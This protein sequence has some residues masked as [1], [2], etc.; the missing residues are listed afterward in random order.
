MKKRISLGAWLRRYWI[1]ILIFCIIVHFFSQFLFLKRMT[2]KV[3]KNLQSSITIAESYFE[4]SLQMVD[5]FI[6]DA[7][8]NSTAMP[9]SN[10]FYLLGHGNS[11]EMTMAKSAITAMLKN[12]DAW[13]D[14]VDGALF[15]T[16]VNSETVLLEAGSVDT[17]TVRKDL[18][19]FIT[20]NTSQDFGISLE[21]YMLF[22]SSGK[23]HMLRVM[24]LE[25]CYFVVHVS[26]NIVMQTLQTAEYDERSIVFAADEAGNIIFSSSPVD[27]LLK[28]ECEGTYIQMAGREYLQTGYVSPRTDYYFGM[29]TD[30]QS[31]TEEMWQF[32][33]AFFGLFLVL[34][35]FIPI[36]IYV[37]HKKLEQPLSRIAAAMKRIEEG[38]LEITVDETSSIS[39][40]GQLINSFNHMM[41]RIRELKIENY[42]VLLD[43]QKVTM[44]YLSLQIKPHFY[45]NALNMIYSLAETKDFE[46]IQHISVAISNYSR[47]RFHDAT[48]LVELK[49]EMEHVRDYMEMQR[50]R[51]GSWIKCDE[52]ISE[53][54]WDALIP[55]FIIQSF[56]ENSMKYAFN[57]KHG[58][59]IQVRASLDA[60]DNLVIIIRDNGDGYPKDLLDKDWKKKNEEGHIGL[61]NVWTRMNL[62][63]EDGA[64]I[65]L[66]NDS[67]AVAVLTIPYIAISSE[68]VEGAEI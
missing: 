7:Y 30:K 55:P 3:E 34:V 1:G 64:N 36:S 49:R 13:S 56:V 17:Y 67:G 19:N 50:I 61:S 5:N 26:E 59:E 44:Q 28:L 60:E 58:C 53:Q 47:Y 15:Y 40:F 4:D 9:D 66:Y 38:D 2:D 25:N 18:R 51:Y 37:I 54:L 39:E 11:F 42:E 16:N 27:I 20:Q 14:M 48:E 62:I 12:L 33:L 24:R 63:Y 52:K 41:N 32:R 57:T 31:I 21:R 29:L 8:S 45:A 22:E 46:K 10:P 65:D 6:Y 23:K 35:V 68:E 43:A